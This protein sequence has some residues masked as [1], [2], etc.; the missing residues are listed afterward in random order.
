MDTIHTEGGAVTT[1]TGVVFSD[2]RIVSNV[3]VL[4][5]LYAE[6]RYSLSIPVDCNTVPGVQY[7]VI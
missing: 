7:L 4:H 3:F 5:V 1:K 2:A 6:N